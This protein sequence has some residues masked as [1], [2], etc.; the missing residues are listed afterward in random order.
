MKPIRGKIRIEGKSFIVPSEGIGK[1]VIVTGKVARMAS[2]IDAQLAED[3]LEPASFIIALK[4][5]GLR[6]DVFTFAQRP[7][8][9]QPKYDYHCEKDNYAAIPITSLNDWMATL[10]QDSRRN[11]GIAKKRGIVVRLVEF[12]DELV[13]GI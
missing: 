7:T 12:N 13:K 10:S 4:K 1:T 6:A 8:D 2:V 11:V 5:S 9:H 3:D